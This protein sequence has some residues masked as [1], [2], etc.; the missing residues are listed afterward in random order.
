MVIS[1]AEE[2][3]IEVNPRGRPGISRQNHR[4]EKERLNIWVGVPTAD[5]IRELSESRQE[6]YS[7]IAAQLLERGMEAFLDD[8]AGKEGGATL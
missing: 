1:A 8:E 2:R 7:M 4:V 5:K 6:S 3:E